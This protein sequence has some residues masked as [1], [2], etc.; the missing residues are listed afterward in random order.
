VIAATETNSAPAYG[1]DTESGLALDAELTL[2]EVIYASRTAAPI[3]CFA[4][5]DLDP[6]RDLSIY[7]Q[8]AN[9]QRRAQTYLH[10]AMRRWA[11]RATT[12]PDL[13]AALVALAS[14]L[15]AGGRGDLAQLAGEAAGGDAETLLVRSIEL[16]R[17]LGAAQSG[18]AARAFTSRLGSELD[19]LQKLYPATPLQCMDVYAAQR[20]ARDYF[21]IAQLPVAERRARTVAPKSR[22]PLADLVQ[23]AAEGLMHATAKFDPSFKVPF[24]AY[25]HRSIAQRLYRA[26]P[27][28]DLI[29]LPQR[30][31]E[32]RSDVRQAITKAA[33]EG[34]ATS[35]PVLAAY[36]GLPERVVRA[37]L[38][39][40]APVLSLDGVTGRILEDTYVSEGD[41]SGEARVEENERA[42]VVQRALATCPP[43]ERSILCQL[44]GIGCPERPVEQI[45]KQHGLSAARVY[46][47]RDAEIRRLRRPAVAK[48]LVA[49]A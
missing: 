1:S 40:D 18:P 23:I 4:I 6:L 39:A 45:A 47:I 17:G 42:A 27:S 31:H 28:A 48:T 9:T 43:R 13:D 29:P 26:E 25:A 5:L 15:R 49:Y 37:V 19:A 36:L 20:L 10:A 46:Q 14:E 38:Q 22:L 34:F 44:F 12:A 35:T 3:V 16:A 30:V 8:L 24:A 7:A 33:T 32:A 21:V 41:Q 11:V 2:G